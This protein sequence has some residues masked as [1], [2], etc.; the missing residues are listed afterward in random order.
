MGQSLRKS[1]TKVRIFDR[2][3]T[4][5]VVSKTH[6]AIAFDD[7]QSEPLLMTNDDAEMQF[8]VS[9]F[10]VSDMKV[11][12]AGVTLNVTQKIEHKYRMVYVNELWK[13]VGRGKTGGKKKRKQA[14]ANAQEILKD[15]RPISISTLGA[16]A[17]LEKD[18]I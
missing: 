14:I 1:G 16:W 10:F 8:G 4:L 17:K 18:H 6:V 11:S 15:G 3:A 2:P 7:N 12:T 13:I 5:Q 9:L